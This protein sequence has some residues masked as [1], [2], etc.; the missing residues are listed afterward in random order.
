MH[1]M[2]DQRLKRDRVPENWED[3]QEEYALELFCVRFHGE[4]L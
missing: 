3:I 2:G 4:T 1:E